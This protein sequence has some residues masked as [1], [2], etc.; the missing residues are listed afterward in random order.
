M[1]GFLIFATDGIFMPNGLPL[2]GDQNLVW[3]FAAGNVLIGI[4]YYI[5][6]ASLAW[7]V[8]KRRDLSFNWLICMFSAFIFAGGTTHIAKTWTMWHASFWP[9]AVLDFST[10]ILSFITAVLMWRLIPQLLRIPSADEVREANQRLQA[11][12]KR[13]EEALQNWQHTKQLWDS[14][15]EHTPMSAFLKDSEDR[16]VFAN[17]S[18][19][20][21]LNVTVD[22]V[23]GKRDGDW[24]PPD[25]VARISK[26]D[27]EV[28]E[29]G[30]VVETVETVSTGTNESKKFLV[31]KFPVQSQGD[32][33]TLI[34]G[35]AYDVTELENAH[36]QIR[37]LN[38]ELQGR[39]VE[40]EMVNTQL[41]AAR[42]Q[43]LEA[44]KLKSQFVANIS[45]EVRTPM[46]GVLGMAE[47]LVDQDNLDNDAREI[48]QH[49]YQSAQ[50]LLHVVNDLLDFSKLEAGK[51][52]LEVEDFSVRHLID[53]VV[54]S[55]TPAASKKGLSVASKFSEGI[56]DKVKGDPGRV[57]QVLLNLAHN[58]VKFTS[59][60]SVQ[61]STELGEQ[62][63]DGITLVFAVTDTG[64]G[65]EKEIQRKLFEPFV[66]AD[67]STTRTYGGTGLGLSI[68][69]SLI[70]LMN[71][72]IG[73]ESE[74]GKGST[75]WIAVPFSAAETS[76]AVR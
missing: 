50:S 52:N 23:I 28:R 18:F 2:I 39:I 12:V 1:P 29:T 73:L 10:G 15:M 45:H 35:L 47:L 27:R 55:I 19:E 74:K 38:Q 62:F 26:T 31:V 67:G 7:L 61:I 63:P 5:I 13:K 32:A 41:Q 42:D 59:T 65:I 14:F 43:A 53:D 20:K 56:P 37:Q 48:A 22:G 71:G 72:Q 25:V 57:R 51:I 21:Q 54:N 75:F 76:S 16:Y 4:S 33:T 64:I 11:E 68:C 40:L 24:L 34:G 70:S 9:S 66:Q 17:K 46:S 36:Q 58:A 30:R 60:G 49:I 3:I 6:A 44:S 69:K 8:Y